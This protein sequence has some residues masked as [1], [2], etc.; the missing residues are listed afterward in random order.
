MAS[1]GHPLADT[2][3]G[4][5]SFLS[6]LR[7][8]VDEERFFGTLLIT[9]MQLLLWFLLII[10]TIIVIYLSLVAWEPRMGVDWWQAPFAF[11]RNYAQIFQDGRF[12]AAIGRSLGVVVAAGGLEFAVGLGLALLFM[13]DFP[14]K[15][16]VTS[17]ILYPMMLP[18]VVVGLAFYLLFLD[19]GPVN[20]VLTQWFG[21]GAT[22]EWFK[23]PLLAM[24]TIVL[25]DIWQWTPFLFL[26]LYSG[27]GAL[28]KDPV[29]AAM[30]LGANRWQIFRHVT[31]PML[32]PV[33]LIALV[34]RALEAFKI[35]DL[36]FVMTG[37]GPGTST[38]TISL[39]IYRVGFVFGQLS[40]A[41][42]MAV[43]I[44]V[45]ITLVTRFAIQPIEEG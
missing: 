32:K 29:E 45:M 16:I 44:L 33:I 39:Y 42:A 31:L 3:E 17:V 28:P 35:F 30:N 14:G 19:R 23:N 20:F 36:V 37:G 27:L 6:R 21:S 40:Y 2:S 41:A 15:R 26:I 12:W 18:W 5:A 7:R 13:R 38:E 34:I 8:A 22:V 11:L 25:A 1:S 24:G 10:P 9:P 43:L 4:R